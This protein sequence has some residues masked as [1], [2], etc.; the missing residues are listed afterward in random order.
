MVKVRQH[1]RQCAF[2]IPPLPP[3]VPLPWQL[4]SLVPSVEKRRKLDWP[5]DLRGY[6]DNIVETLEQSSRELQEKR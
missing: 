5:L 2:D 1:I 3:L 4:D 6:R